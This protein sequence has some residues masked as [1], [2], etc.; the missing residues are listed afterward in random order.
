MHQLRSHE[1]PLVEGKE[2]TMAQKA[3]APSTT[4]EEPLGKSGSVF[5]FVSCVRRE[6]EKVFK[7]GYSTM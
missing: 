5:S 1:I 2:Q 3:P 4:M 7:L 6:G